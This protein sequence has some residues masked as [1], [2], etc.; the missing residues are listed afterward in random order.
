MGETLVVTL[1]VVLFFGF[2]TLISN[3]AEKEVDRYYEEKRKAGTRS[4]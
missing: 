4:R 3:K 1:L 2:F